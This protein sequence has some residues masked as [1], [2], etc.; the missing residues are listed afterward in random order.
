MNAEPTPFAARPA[1]VLDVFFASAGFVITVLAIAGLATSSATA[2]GLPD[3]AATPEESRRIS[4]ALTARG[5]LDVHDIEVDDGRFE[6]DVHH[7]DGYELELELDVETLEI[8][9]AE[10]V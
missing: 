9:R 6:V 3:R 1:P 5:Y 2:E 4:E 7:R 8:V 10:P